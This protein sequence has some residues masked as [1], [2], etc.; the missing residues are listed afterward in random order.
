M[1]ISESF[2]DVPTVIVSESNVLHSIGEMT[3]GR[4][5][6]MTTRLWDTFNLYGKTFLNNGF[7]LADI[8]VGNVI[9]IL[10]RN[11]SY[12]FISKE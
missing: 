11:T 1:I 3:G 4:S 2:N 9:F 7:F 5:R 12:R 6:Y 10:K 8:N